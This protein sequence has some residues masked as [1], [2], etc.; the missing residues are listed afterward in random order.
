MPHVC[1]TAFSESRFFDARTELQNR[2]R[3]LRVYHRGKH[4]RKQCP[5]DHGLQLTWIK[6]TLLFSC[7]RLNSK[8][9]AG[10][11]DSF[12]N[13]IGPNQPGVLLGCTGNVGNACGA[14]KSVVIVTPIKP[15]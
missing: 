10:C 11:G 13:A 12:S 5:F 8:Y 2:K 6:S 15:P 3:L 4:Q 1:N 14:R 9:F 7:F